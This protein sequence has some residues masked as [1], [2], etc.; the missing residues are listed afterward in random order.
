MRPKPY[1]RSLDPGL[2]LGYRRSANGGS[3]LA[4]IYLGQ[5]AYRL[6]RVATADDKA[7]AD[8]VAVLSFSQAQ[9]AARALFVSATRRAA[10]LPEAGPYT[11]G[12]A[13]NEYISWLEQE[14]RTARDARWAADAFI[15]PTL[16]HIRCDLLPLLRSR[17]G[18]TTSQRPLPAFVPRKASNPTTRKWIR[19]TSRY[20]DGDS[21]AQIES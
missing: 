3:W 9:A 2:H 14:R 17:N 10:G 18:S 21:R 16:G 4:R 19:P 13:L 12:S 5:Q 6:E 1:Y 11:V 15:L 8:G 20:G 7:D